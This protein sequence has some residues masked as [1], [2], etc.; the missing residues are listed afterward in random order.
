[1]QE[2]SKQLM[3]NDYDAL[4]RLH[5]ATNSA[6]KELEGEN[7]RLRSQ[8]EFLQRQVENAD[9]RVAIQKQIVIDNLNQSREVH[10]NLVAEILALKKEIKELKAA[11]G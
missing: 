2:K 6:V 1:M 9:K 3:Q 5:D 7:A 10:D 11:E 8:V 4:R